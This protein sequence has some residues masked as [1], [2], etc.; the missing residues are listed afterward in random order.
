M[1]TL[2]APTID[3][4][5]LL[6]SAT[7]VPESEATFLNMFCDEPLSLFVTVTV[8]EVPPP[9]IP[10]PAVT[11]VISPT[12]VVYPAPLVIASLFKDMLAEPLKLTP[13]IVLAV[14]NTVA[15]PAF[16]VIVV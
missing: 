2:P 6:L 10:D 16:P 1:V 3:N 15:E 7:A 9:L 13:A 4:V 14:C 8:P 5:S 12:L 11:P